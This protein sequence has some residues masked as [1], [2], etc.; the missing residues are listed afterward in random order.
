MIDPVGLINRHGE[1]AVT[2]CVSALVI[3]FCVSNT[4]M[5]KISVEID[6]EVNTWEG[7]NRLSDKI[8]TYVF[9]LP[10]II[11]MSVPSHRKVIV[12]PVSSVEV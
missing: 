1:P 9:L 4:S 10:P 6:I 11:S 2:R 12:A 3:P 8:R 5:S 7:D